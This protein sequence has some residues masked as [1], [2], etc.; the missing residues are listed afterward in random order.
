MK[1]AINVPSDAHGMRID[2]FLKDQDVTWTR[3]QIKQWIDEGYVLV[4]GVRSKASYKVKTD[5]QIAIDVPEAQPLEL[6]PVRLD[7]EIVY[8]DEALL[9]INKPSGLIVHPSS[10]SDE[11]TLVHGLLAEVEDLS[12]IGDSLRPGIV[13]RLDKD[14]SGLIVVAKTKEAL[15][16]LQKALKEHKAHREYLALVEGVIPHQKGKIDAPIGRD[17]KQR[18]NMAVVANGKPSIT[19]FEVVER[20]D[21]HTLIRCHLESGRTHQ[22]RVHLQYIG[23][24]IYGDPKYGRRKTEQ[25]YGQYLHATK[26]GFTHP[27]TDVF[28]EFESKLP[29][30]FNDKLAS[31]RG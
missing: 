24:P 14:T 16:H 15:L 10:T 6:E 29:E 18:K 21:E 13:H 28:V 25:E 8:Q 7:L 2:Q 27:T 4:N 3:T 30:Y 9:V 1:Q 31:L 22:I 11:V 23:Y 17:P 5:D 12:A 20:F 19:H 26:L